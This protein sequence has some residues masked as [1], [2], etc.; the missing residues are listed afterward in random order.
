MPSVSE[1]ERE[2]VEAHS[3]SKEF[4]DRATDCFTNGVTHDARYANPFPIY[5]ERAS[6]TK[7]W[8]VDGNEYVDYTMGHGS[9]L[10][11]YGHERVRDAFQEQIEKAVHMGTSTELEIEWAELIKKLVPCAEE[12]LIRAHSSGSEAIQMAI[13]L[14]RIHTG[15]EKVV[16]QADSYHGKADQV[17]PPQNG[18]PFGMRN[19]RGIPASVR[20]AVKIVPL[21]DL[22]ALEQALAE[23][24]VACVLLHCNNLYERGYVEGIRELTETY[25]SVFVMDEVV[26]GFRYAAGG[27]Q[28]Y[29]G[30]TPDLAVLGKIIGGGAPVGAVC[31]DEEILRYYEISDD[32]HWNDYVR[33]KVGGTWNAQPL[34]IVGGIATMELIDEERETIYPRLYQIGTRLVE[35]FNE[36]ANDLGVTAHAYGLPAGDP[37]QIKLEFFDRPV[38]PE[39]MRLFRTG[40]VTFEDYETRQSYSAPE[41]EH[42]HYLAMSNNGI[43]ALHRG[44]AL[45]TCTEYSEADL[46][47]T[48]EAFGR[49][50]EIL[51]ENDLVGSV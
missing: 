39:D 9:L 33:V 14:A 8:D 42:A 36:L 11:G 44:R 45:T 43:H 24:D 31:G 48:E 10:F 28:E 38:P 37:T 34:S 13:R 41:A 23:G 6:G 1:L 30:V 50:L 2:Y 47:K 17:I 12:G 15:R 27:A 25:G 35:T 16:L 4:H 3:V 40:P 51:K 20:D 22:D 18:P 19:V 29:Y 49:S 7:K 21:N 46:R 26:S 5:A 32:E